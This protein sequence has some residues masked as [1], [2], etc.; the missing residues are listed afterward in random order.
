MG[1]YTLHRA[2]TGPGPRPHP[3]FLRVAAPGPGPLPFTPG[4]RGRLKGVGCHPHL[5]FFPAP[6]FMLR[7]AC[8]RPPSDPLASCPPPAP[9]AAT[10]SPDSTRGVAAVVSLDEPQALALLLWAYITPLYL[11]DLQDPTAHRR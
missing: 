8:E 10:I 6:P 7:L 5:P 1:C 2:T 9:E 4:H 11:Y 3:T